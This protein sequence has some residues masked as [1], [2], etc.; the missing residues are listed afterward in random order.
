MKIHFSVPYASHAMRQFAEPVIL[1]LQARGVAITVSD[2]PDADADLNYH[3]PWHTMAGLEAPNSKHVIDFTHLNPGMEAQAV[4]ACRRADAVVAMTFA[5]REEL[6]RLGVQQDKLWVSSPG[7]SGFTPRK[8]N[9]GIV[10]AEQPNGRKRS[11]ILLDLAWQTDL[12]P[13]HFI[14]IG[15]GWEPVAEQL[16]NMGVSGEVHPA[17]SEDQLRAAYRGMDALLVTGYREGGP[18]PVL[19]ALSAGVPVF[20][21]RYGYAAD[22]WDV[23]GGNN[24]N[25]GHITLYDGAA[26]LGRALAEW[27]APLRARAEMAQFYSTERWVEDH[28]RLF[29]RV[30]GEALPSLTEEPKRYDQ[31]LAIAD[32]LKPKTV[33]EVG[34]WR[35]DRA[36]Q[37]IQ[38][39]L[40]YHKPHEVSY[41]GFDL[42]AEGMTPTL[43]EQELSKQPPRRDAVDSWLRTSGARIN[44][45]AGNTRDTLER[46][47]V[48]ADLMFL[49][50]GHSHSTIASDWRALAPALY[51]GV[52]CVLD[53]FYSGDVPEGVGCQSLIDGLDRGTWDVAVLP[54]T[55][56]FEKPWGRLNIQMV[57][58]KRKLAMQ[59][60][61]TVT[62]T[63]G[64]IQVIGGKSQ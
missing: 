15:T 35:G 45:V 36:M 31:L 53:D 10:G 43:M 59:Q 55:D 30:M 6:L 1:A 29:E 50:G 54:V 52:V 16:K 3:V 4:D 62:A 37:L 12:S 17:V 63:T 40:R 19:E 18:L 22:L 23:W 13:F 41:Y 38:T 21:P 60:T 61:L 58:V 42:F 26:D 44:L 34:T 47:R 28:L 57:T 25:V 49:D 2:A 7:V 64:N 8:R 39:A 20:S 46:N 9:I 14:I 27:A 5:G 24:R 32:A 33:L 51:A 56:S 48:A 11:H